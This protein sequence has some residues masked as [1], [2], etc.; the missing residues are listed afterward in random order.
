VI[1]IMFLPM[2]QALAASIREHVAHAVLSR[3]QGLFPGIA[4]IKKR[5]RDKGGRSP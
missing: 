5:S 3:T 4:R 2:A 1:A